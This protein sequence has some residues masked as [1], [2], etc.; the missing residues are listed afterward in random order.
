MRAA[1]GGITDW[2]TIRG[3]QWAALARTND[4]QGGIDPGSGS[5][6][7]DQLTIDQ[8]ATAW[9]RRRVISPRKWLRR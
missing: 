6:V 1:L 4:L 8:L 5:Y 7:L 9:C 3:L 2:V